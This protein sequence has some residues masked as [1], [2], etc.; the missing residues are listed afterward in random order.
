MPKG[1]NPYDHLPPT[2]DAP[3]GWTA[4]EHG[5]PRP[6]KRAPFNPG[7][8]RGKAASEDPGGGNPDEETAITSPD[9]AEGAPLAADPD[10]KHQVPDEGGTPRQLV[11]VTT[12]VRKDI[13]AK[14]ALLLGFPAMAVKRK[15]PYCGTV[16]VEQVP[17]ISDAL[18]DIICESPDLVAFF[19]SGSSYM[20]YLALATA[21]QPVAETAWGHHV[22][23]KIGGKEIKQGAGP[24]AGPMAPADSGR[25]HAPAFS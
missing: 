15:D 24:A 20:K 4:D 22:S 9:D 11:R 2:E 23:H 10:A 21:L 3:F 17:E 6:R 13:R 7:G 1:K 8:G 5:Q 14:V 19:T 16:I 25:Y 12:A 18:V